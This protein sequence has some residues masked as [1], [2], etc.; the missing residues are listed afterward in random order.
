M[1]VVR[2]EEHRKIVRD[3]RMFLPFSFQ[4][5]SIISPYPSYMIFL[6][7]LTACFMEE[8]RIAVPFLQPINMGSLPLE[9]IY[10]FFKPF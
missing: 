5:Y 2:P 8:G 4:P 3:K 9:N 7:P 6:L 1:C 10:L